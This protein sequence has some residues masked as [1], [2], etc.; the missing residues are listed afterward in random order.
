MKKL[1]SLFVLLLLIGCKQNSSEK[2]IP[3][4]PNNGI[5]DGATP[6]PVLSFSENIEEAHNKVAF[7]NRPAISFDIKLQFG[8]KTSLEGKVSMTTNSSKVRLDRADGA[9]V[10]YDG[11]QVHISPAS[12][13]SDRARF[14]VFTWQYFFAMPFKLTDPGTVWEEEK[15]RVLDSLQY[16]T[17]KLSFGSNI[18]DSPDDWYVVYKDPET[19]RL[20]AAAYIVTF[21][22]DR[23]KAEE[24]PHAIV[25]SDYTNVE[26]V[27]L[28]TK[29]SFHNWNEENGLGEKLGEAVITNI[30]F[31]DP[32]EGYFTAP[33]DS[34]VIKK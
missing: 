3:V 15:N 20:K 25:Y 24:D 17:A 5:G 30:K 6:P 34:Q 28:A 14:N 31:F 27:A 1:I 33:A 7:M 19:S 32:Q 9:S 11:E 22:K 2:R 4:E 10:I 21:S 18:G 16:Q 29:W 8:G 12:A 23:E 13:T 26:N